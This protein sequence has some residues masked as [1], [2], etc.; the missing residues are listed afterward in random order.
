MAIL[1]T[2][3]G[4]GIMV[5]L[6]ELGHFLVAKKFGVLV[7]EFAIG[8]GPKLISFGRGETQYS[9]RLIPI[10]GFVKL[11][12]EGEESKDDDPRSFSNLKPLKRIAILIAGAAMNIVLGWIIFT[13]IN[14]NVGI[15]PSVVSSISTDFNSSQNI[16]KPGDEI[17][18]LNSTRTHTFDDVALFM[19][20][21]NG[22]DINIKY[23]RNGKTYTDSIKPHKTDAGY[24][25]GVVFS[26][27][28]CN[29]LTG[30]R[31]A[32]YDTI[33]ISKA[34]ILAVGDLFSGRQNL[35]A[36]SG[37]VEIV[38]VVDSVTSQKNSYA[39]LSVLMLFAMI[40]VNLGIFNLLPFPALDGGSIVFALYEL[41]FRR[42]I[43]QEI[44]GYVGF[45]GFALLMLLAVYVTIGD[46][47]ALI[48]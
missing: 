1:I 41:I 32:I 22:E 4:F 23:K 27:Q 37:P 25:L 20:R 33:Y 21:T 29:V 11:E 46:I 45:V 2:L 15:T 3:I 7:H 8:M 10:G 48:N 19:S 35:D 5:F 30:A 34:V 16:L 18:R 17:I 6:H 39:L 24:K 40:T 28:E 47:R 38:T 26:P 43:K 31:Y 36:L 9:L 14:V 13:I 44:I 42:K 12:G